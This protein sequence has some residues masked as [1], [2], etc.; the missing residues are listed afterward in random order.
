M[1]KFHLAF[2]FNLGGY[3]F[4]QAGFINLPELVPPVYKACIM[5]CH[6]MFYFIHTL[7]RSDA[8]YFSTLFSYVKLSCSK[9]GHLLCYKIL[10]EL[11]SY[12]LN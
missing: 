10:S 2:F 4:W 11:L 9:G 8:P 1:G 7:F 6:L 3:R 5:S 12:Y